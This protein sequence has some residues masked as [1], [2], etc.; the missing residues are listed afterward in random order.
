MFRHLRTTAKGAAFGKG[1]R[2]FIRLL[3]VSFMLILRRYSF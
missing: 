2:N 1:G 3:Y